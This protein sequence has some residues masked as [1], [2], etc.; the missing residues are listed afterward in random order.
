MLTIRII[1][2]GKKASWG[3]QTFFADK[4]MKRKSKRRVKYGE[5]GQ[6][7]DPVGALSRTFR[8]P[9]KT[10]A[11]IQKVC[12][13]KSRD[14]RRGRLSDG[15]EGIQ[16]L[17]TD[18]DRISLF[19]QTPTTQPPANNWQGYALLAFVSTRVC[20]TGAYAGHNRKEHKGMSSPSTPPPLVPVSV[21]CKA[22]ATSDWWNNRKERTMR[23][24][25]DL[26]LWSL[27]FQNCF[28]HDNVLDPV[29]F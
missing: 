9:S 28:G 6:R 17:I 19:Q 25:T 21:Y 15:C 12:Q 3:H 13:D 5:Q 16:A 14:W 2:E 20:Q 18:G 11:L 29:V 1:D 10:M 27:W 8:R 26:N 7:R 22:R 4:S 23:Y 24:Q